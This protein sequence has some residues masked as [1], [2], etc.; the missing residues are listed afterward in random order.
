MFASTLYHGLWGLC[1]SFM[2]L[3]FYLHFSQC[4]YKLELL[5]AA[6]FCLC[7]SFTYAEVVWFGFFQCVSWHGGVDQGI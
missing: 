4:L 7:Y 6:F 2:I 1:I 5:S 3:W